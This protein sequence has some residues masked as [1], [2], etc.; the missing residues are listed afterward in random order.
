MIVASNRVMRHLESGNRIRAVF[1][2]VNR[3]AVG[4]KGCGRTARL[5]GGHWD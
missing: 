5:G 2:K 3:G 4:G 1:K